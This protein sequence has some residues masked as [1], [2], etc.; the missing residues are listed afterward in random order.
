MSPKHDFFSFFF[1]F[2]NS[3]FKQQSGN[4][5]KIIYF[6]VGLY[7]QHFAAENQ[8]R[9]W[10]LKTHFYSRKDWAAQ[11]FLYNPRNKDLWFTLDVPDD[12][13]FILAWTS[14]LHSVNMHLQPLFST[15]P[16]NII[17]KEQETRKQSLPEDLQYVDFHATGPVQ[18]ITV[19]YHHILF[20][21][22][23]IPSITKPTRCRSESLMFQITTQ[24]KGK[25]SCG[26]YKA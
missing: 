7:V 14:P 26:A 18:L 3:R 6:A 21:I 11:I 13:I 19:N 12:R 24:Q 16:E 25:Q 23:Y 5:G 4:L 9:S 15:D 22:P 20:Q 2:R 17:I 8:W 1:F 10:L